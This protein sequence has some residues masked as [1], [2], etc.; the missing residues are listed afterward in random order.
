MCKN[1]FAIFFVSVAI[2]IWWLRGAW[3]HRRQRDT[4]GRW[5]Y[6]QSHRHPGSEEWDDDVCVIFMCM[7]SVGQIVNQ[8]YKR[9][10]KKGKENTTTKKI[11]IIIKIIKLG[12]LECEFMRPQGCNA[13]SFGCNS[14]VAQLSFSRNLRTRKS[15]EKGNQNFLGNEQQN[16]MSK[17]FCLL[18][19]RW[20][21]RQ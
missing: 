17:G 9:H 8:E 16:L 15:F 12:L 18:C 21:Q 6:R 13:P 7:S 3:C 5:M 2:R 14:V 10:G 20:C 11:V 1:R 19:R 4:N